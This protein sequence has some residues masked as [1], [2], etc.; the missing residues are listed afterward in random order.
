M[1]PSAGSMPPA[2]SGRLPPSCI[3]C[4]YNLRGL[5]ATGNCPECGLS[6]AES[7]RA[8]LLRFA[9]SAYLKT[10]LK[11]HSWVVNCL[12]VLILGLFVI[13]PFAVITI[14][15][16]TRVSPDKIA[17]SGEAAE[18][19]SAAILLPFALSLFGYWNLTAPDPQFS[20]HDRPDAA[21]KIVRACTTIL[22]VNFAVLG[23]LEY[24]LPLP[25]SDT[26][27]N[28]IVDLMHWIGVITMS[29]G[30]AAMM[31]HARWF[32]R[33]IP[34]ARLVRQAALYRWLLPSLTLAFWCF[35]HLPPSSV[36]SFDLMLLEVFG[37]LVPPLVTLTLY[38]QLLNRTRKH[39]RSIVA[40]GRPAAL[41]GAGG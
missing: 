2:A 28:T 12:L 18:A 11:G 24:L 3:R 19:F 41:K 30:L 13:L 29:I 6:I 34:D 40:H 22:L 5:G 17:S 36:R 15:A 14:A 9:G 35:L 31:T 7:L 1:D 26:A 39:L 8:D 38:W 10:V 20:G 33:R 32:A 16:V 23:A 27:T 21:R 37:S 4:N 25:F